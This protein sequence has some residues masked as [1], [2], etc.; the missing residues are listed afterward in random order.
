[1]PKTS[2]QWL[3]VGALVG[4]A[5]IALAHTQYPLPAWLAALLTTLSAAVF[6]GVGPVKDRQR[7]DYDI[8]TTL[9]LGGP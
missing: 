3:V 7:D 9:P 2:F 5:I 4:F 1:M 8:P 6:G